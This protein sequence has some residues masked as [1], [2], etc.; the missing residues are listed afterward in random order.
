MRQAHQADFGIDVIAQ[1]RPIEAGRG[2]RLL[3]PIMIVE[4]AALAQGPRIR[5]R[6]VDDVLDAGLDGGGDGVAMLGE[7]PARLVECVRR[8]EEQA[9]DTGERGAER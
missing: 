6:G 1:D 5:C 3:A 9:V 4:N 2:K 7:A 8:D